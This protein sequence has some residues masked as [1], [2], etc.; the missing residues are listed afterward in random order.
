MS[1]VLARPIKSES[2]LTFGKD[3]LYDLELEDT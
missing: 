3:V 2:V 1:T